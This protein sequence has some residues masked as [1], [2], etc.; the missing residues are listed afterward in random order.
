M[1]ID[2]IILGLGALVCVAAGA[3]IVAIANRFNPLQKEKEKLKDEN[4]R[5]KKQMAGLYELFTISEVV[6]GENLYVIEYMYPYTHEFNLIAGKER[7]KKIIGLLE[8][9]GFG[10][11]NW[12]KDGFRYECRY[13]H[14]IRSIRIVEQVTL[15]RPES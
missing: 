14:S 3:I 9:Y 15:D 8:A 12:S 1:S 5:L 6:F 2:T 10:T 13:Q 4:L 7:K 11:D